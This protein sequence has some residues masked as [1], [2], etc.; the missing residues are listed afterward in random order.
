MLKRIY[1]DNFRCLVN[2]ELSVDGINLFLGPNGTG[3]SA[4]FD[5]LRKIQEFVRGRKVMHYI[6]NADDCTRWQTSSIKRFELEIE[7]NGGTYKYE[8]FLE[9]EQDLEKKYIFVKQERLFFDNQILLKVEYGEVEL[10]HEDSSGY[11][12]QQFSLNMTQ[13]VLPLIRPTKRT[14]KM[15]RSKE[16]IARF[17]IVKIH[18][19]LMYNGS[20]GDPHLD[21]R[22]E[23]FVSWY[24]DM[25]QD[26]S[27]IIQ[28]TNE[29]KEILDGFA[30]FKFAGRGRK[31][32]IL[33]LYFSREGDREEYIEY[34]FGELSDGQRV[35][36]A[37]YSLIYCIQSEDYTLCIDEPE[38]FLALPEIQPWLM[39]LYD[40][41]SEVKTQALLISHHPELIDMLASSVGYW[42]DRESN[43]PVRVKRIKDDKETGLPIS[44]LV[45]RGWLYD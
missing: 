14:I 18:P 5:V 11:M 2:F 36:I 41:C 29:L 28:L 13:S 25:S 19:T 7:G 40:F 4:V 3:K 44:E 15:N 10:Y 42:F 22:M 26:Q 35:L 8:L 21:A 20:Y 9:H 43:S 31:K 16:I 24:R 17:I 23:N 39:Q 30:Y 37:L 6:F 12:L 45:A 1:I 32:R 27:K 34:D 38:N 33:K